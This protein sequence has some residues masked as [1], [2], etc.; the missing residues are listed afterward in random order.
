MARTAKPAQVTRLDTADRLLPVNEVA[1]YL[2][3]HR[4][5]VYRMMREGRLPYQ[6]VGAHRRVRLSD[7]QAFLDE[8]AS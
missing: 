5:F 1:T 3:A 8:A 2:G 6:M 7:L 4:A